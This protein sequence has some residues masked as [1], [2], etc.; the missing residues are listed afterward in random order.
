[1]T[2]KKSL[3]TFVFAICLMIPAM[4][5]LTAC[6]HNHKATTEWQSDA[7]YHW[8]A[9]EGKNC[10]EQLDKAEHTWDAGVITTQAT[11]TTEAVKTFTCTVCE[12]TKTENS[13]E[14]RK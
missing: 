11:D 10:K 4:F 2:K 7:S 6:G 14:E 13:G 8:H 5:M 1:M 9:C 12:K 3:L